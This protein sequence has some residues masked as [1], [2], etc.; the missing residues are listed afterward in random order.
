[1]PGLVSP[2]PPGYRGP[3]DTS[4]PSGVNLMHDIVHDMNED[5]ESADA[6]DIFHPGF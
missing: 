2:P 6:D 4:Q 5:L 3:A 1:M